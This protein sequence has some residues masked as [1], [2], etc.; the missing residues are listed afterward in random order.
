MQKVMILVV[1]LS[2]L[3]GRIWLSTVT[4]TFNQLLRRLENQ[5]CAPV[6]AIGNGSVP[7]DGWASG[8][9]RPLA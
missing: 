4:G 7:H 8:P 2:S 1:F 6:L 9:S 5:K 3:G